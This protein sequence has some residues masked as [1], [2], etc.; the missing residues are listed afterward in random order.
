LNIKIGMMGNG[1]RF[2]ATK[3]KHNNYHIGR[4]LRTG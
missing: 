3:T 1:Q 2:N 4:G